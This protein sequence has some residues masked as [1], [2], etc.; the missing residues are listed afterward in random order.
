V[1]NVGYEF[2]SGKF[3]TIDGQINA[4]NP[5]CIK[6]LHDI[7]LAHWTRLYFPGQ[8]FNL[9][10][11]NIAESLNKA[12]SKGSASHIMEL[13]RFIRSMLTRW[14]N[15]RQKKLQAHSGPVLSEVDKQISKIL[16]T[17]NGSKVGR[18]YVPTCY[19][20]QNFT[21]KWRCWFNR[22]SSSNPSCVIIFGF[23]NY[24]FYCN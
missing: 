10:T 12:L 22:T 11:S 4:I 1:K 17:S 2:T 16:T 18:R 24:V 23:S 7:G 15:A 8:R 13:I 20:I 19:S 21:S 3:K 6:Y 14:F 9:M 5:L